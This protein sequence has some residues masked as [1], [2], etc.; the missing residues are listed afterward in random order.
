MKILKGFCSIVLLF[1]SVIVFAQPTPL[2]LWQTYDLKQT[3][4]DIIRISANNH[5]LL[6]TIV[7]SPNPKL[8]GKKIIW[9][10]TQKSNTWENGYVLNVDDGKI[11]R[12]KIAVSDDNH[13][14]YFSPYTGIPL[15]G[16]TIKWVRVG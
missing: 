1:F 4:R 12:C 13:T 3:P 10:L 16:V 8:I 6:G 11:Y 14:L 9:G 15:F 7:K 2:G 5:Q